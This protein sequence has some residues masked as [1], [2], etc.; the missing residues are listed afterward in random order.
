MEGVFRFDLR[1][2]QGS[3]SFEGSFGATP[4]AILN[5]VSEPAAFIRFE[6][7]RVQRI[8]CK[9]QFSRQ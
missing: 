2:P 1:D 9:L 8:L 6:R 4:F 7:G 3:H 5:P